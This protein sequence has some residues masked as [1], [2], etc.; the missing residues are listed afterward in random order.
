MDVK[1]TI[2][3]TEARSRFF[4]INDEVQTSG[5][6]YTFT[7][8]GR[9]ISTLISAEE[10]EYWQKLLKNKKSFP[11]KSKACYNKIALN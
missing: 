11:K 9:P 5:V 10:F 7:R 8:N 4:E 1:T 2:P 6:R 3:I